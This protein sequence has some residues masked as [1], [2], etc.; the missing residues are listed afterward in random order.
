VLTR[1]TGDSV[2]QHLRP[3]ALAI[4]LAFDHDARKGRLDR[5]A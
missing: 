1:R 2:A 5:F 4:D 3:K